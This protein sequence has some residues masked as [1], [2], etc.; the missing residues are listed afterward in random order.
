MEKTSVS[1]WPVHGKKSV[2]VKKRTTPSE[3]QYLPL[4]GGRTWPFP[5]MEERRGTFVT[6]IV[7]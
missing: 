2:E 4:F 7:K 1:P 5:I 6:S 3:R